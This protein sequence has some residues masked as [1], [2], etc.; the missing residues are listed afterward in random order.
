MNK[1]I[2]LGRLT[3]DPE[4]RQTQAG[5]SVASMTIAVDRP[6]ARNAQDGQQTADF[7]PLVAW[8]RSADFCRTY[9]HKGSKI[10]VEG[11]MAVRNYEAQDGS[12]R[13]VTEVIVQ[14]IEFAE[15]K[16]ADQGW[17]QN[18]GQAPAGG[19]F[20]PAAGYNQAPPDYAGQFGQPVLYDEEIPF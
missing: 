4:I 17:S 19:G 14:N 5:K 9:L 6:R 1:V 10:M 2:L 18:G 15:S 7:I 8:E 20:T 12:K 13:Y 11:R 3:R 16:K